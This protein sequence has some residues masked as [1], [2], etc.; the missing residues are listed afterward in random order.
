[1]SRTPKRNRRG[2]TLIEVAIGAMMMALL[3]VPAMRAMNDSDSLRRRHESHDVMLFTAEEKIEQ[4]KISLSSL[5]YFAAAVASPSGI[6]RI[7]KIDVSNGADLICRTRIV[8]DNSV[9][10][11]PARLVTI[12]VDVWND[13]NGDRRLDTVESRETIQTQW[14][15]P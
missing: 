6:D 11:T 7:E 9:G 12:T 15:S 14:A 2:S 1:M 4:E 3:I 5:A 8:A 10:V 13:L